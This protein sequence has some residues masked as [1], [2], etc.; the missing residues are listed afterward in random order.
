[1]GHSLSAEMS[2]IMVD[3]EVVDHKGNPKDLS[4]IT[5][6]DLLEIYDEI[7]SLYDDPGWEILKMEPIADE[8]QSLCLTCSKTSSDLAS[9]LQFLQVGIEKIGS[10]EW[11]D[12]YLSIGVSE[13]RK[14]ISSALSSIPPI[15]ILFVASDI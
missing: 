7:V 10:P 8:W 6:S 15:I 5:T 14:R 3:R 12:A 2:K 13:I 11:E 9:A 4:E 1:M